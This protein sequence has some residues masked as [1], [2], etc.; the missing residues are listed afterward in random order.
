M[1]IRF[2][3]VW[4]AGR[5]KV[6]CSNCLRKDDESREIT[7]EVLDSALVC[8]V[9]GLRNTPEGYAPMDDPDFLIKKDEE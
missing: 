8:D 6:K 1:K 5:R 2:F 9:C 7:D 4:K 3:A